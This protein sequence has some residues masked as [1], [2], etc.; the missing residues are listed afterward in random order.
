M[1]LFSFNLS[2]AS[3][4]SGESPKTTETYGDVDRLKGANKLEDEE[5][6]S[7]LGPLN[8]LFL[9]VA[10]LLAASA[11]FLIRELT[12]VSFVNGAFLFITSVTISVL[13]FYQPSSIGCDPY[14][15]VWND[16]NVRSVV[17]V[18][19]SAI[20]TEGFAIAGLLCF[21]LSV[22]LLFANFLMELPSV[23]PVFRPRG[24]LKLDNVT[25]LHDIWNHI[26]FN[27]KEDSKAPAT[28][29]TC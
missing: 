2:Q 8:G 12:F 28:L 1:S 24:G 3:T 19:L 6:I 7:R 18:W 9:M 13:E 20:A 29:N 5:E 16:L 4:S 21:L 27:T 15:A 26:P 22:T 11:I 25:G 17:L 14:L 10:A 23:R